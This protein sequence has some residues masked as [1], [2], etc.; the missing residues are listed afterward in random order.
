MLNNRSK[1]L[2]IANFTILRDNFK[3][4]RDDPNHLSRITKPQPSSLCLEMTKICLK[5]GIETTGSQLIY[6]VDFKVNSNI[7]FISKKLF[8]IRALRVFG[9]TRAMY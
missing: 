9:R 4:V 1:V 6:K 2:Y 8:K 5:T 7:T 3:G